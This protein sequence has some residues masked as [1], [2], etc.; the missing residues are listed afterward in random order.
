MKIREAKQSDYEELMQLYNFFVGEDR[1]LKHD[2]DSFNKV[3]NSKNNYI[4][5]AEDNNSLV[6]FITFSV[7]NVVRYPKPIVELDEIFVSKAY[8]KHGIGKKFM[9]KMEEEAIKLNCYR[10]FIESHYD[11]KAA[12]KFYEDLGYKNYGYHFIK[13]L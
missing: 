9:E 10:V 12:H 1:Y 5:V 13:N 2:N 6:G 7:R 4:Y 11:H 8:R 3:L